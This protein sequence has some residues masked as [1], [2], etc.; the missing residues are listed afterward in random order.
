MG[1]GSDGFLGGKEKQMWVSWGL[2]PRKLSLQFISL[3]I[4]RP[5]P[6]S[7][8]ISDFLPMDGSAA[9]GGPPP[10]WPRFV[11]TTPAHVV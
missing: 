7:F 9:G 1:G 2:T 8:G 5:G 6:I 4:A 11:M 3:S 10:P